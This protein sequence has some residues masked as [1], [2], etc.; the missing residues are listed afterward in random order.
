M[1]TWAI[2]LTILGSILLLGFIALFTV[3]GIGMLT[4]V[5]EDRSAWGI[6]VLFLTL[7]IVGLIIGIII[8]QKKYNEL[9]KELGITRNNKILWDYEQR[10]KVKNALKVEEKNKVT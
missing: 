3:I 10:K 8:M 6:L 2:W 7:N 9:L 5:R 1:P 4:C